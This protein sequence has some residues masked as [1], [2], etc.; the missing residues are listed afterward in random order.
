MVSCDWFIYVFLYVGCLWMELDQISH[1]FLQ[2]NVAF[3]I[4]IHISRSAPWSVDFI[5]TQTG[6]R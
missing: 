1:V 4:I 5:A 6:G 3:L 2:E